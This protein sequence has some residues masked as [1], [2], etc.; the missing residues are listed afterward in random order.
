M[1]WMELK[2]TLEI[3]PW[4]DW[5]AFA[6]VVFLV[7][8]FTALAFATSASKHE[9]CLPVSTRETC[10]GCGKPQA[11]IFEGYCMECVMEKVSQ[12]RLCS[13]CGRAWT[14]REPVYEICPVCVTRGGVKTAI[15]VADDFESHPIVSVKGSCAGR[16]SD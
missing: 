13:E 6:V 14:S 12:L 10:N 5:A 3:V 9:S 7:L 2:E 15:P 16:S 1:S 8:T 11:A 4:Y